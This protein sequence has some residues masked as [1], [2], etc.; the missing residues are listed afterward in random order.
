MFTKVPR[1]NQLATVTGK[2]RAGTL[3][4]TL[5]HGIGQVATDCARVIQHS[6][7]SGIEPCLCELIQ[8]YELYLLKDCSITWPLDSAQLGFPVWI[9]RNGETSI[10]TRHGG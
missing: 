7:G 2:I 3:T 1:S 10:S 9:Y 6:P 8:P 4:D 5:C